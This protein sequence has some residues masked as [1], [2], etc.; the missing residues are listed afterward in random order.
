MAHSGN[1]RFAI[2]LHLPRLAPIS[3]RCFGRKPSD[4]TLISVPRTS[5]LGSLVSGAARYIHL[6]TQ[7]L[8]ASSIADSMLKGRVHA[9]RD[10]RDSPLKSQDLFDPL[11]QSNVRPKVTIPASS[12]STSALFETQRSPANTERVVA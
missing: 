8:I 1:D 10:C 9:R 11:A 7:S 5:A 4:W 2:A 3:S 6:S 12:A